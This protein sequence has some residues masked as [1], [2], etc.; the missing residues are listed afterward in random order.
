MMMMVFVFL[1]YSIV[2]AHD[3]HRSAVLGVSCCIQQNNHK[4]TLICH[5]KQSEATTQAKCNLALSNIK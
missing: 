3:G 5:K 1:F 4:Q 2:S